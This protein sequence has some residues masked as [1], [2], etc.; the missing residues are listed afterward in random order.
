MPDPS[1]DRTP[2]GGMPSG[3]ANHYTTA[4]SFMIEDYVLGLFRSLSFSRANES[5]TGYTFISCEWYFTCPD[6]GNR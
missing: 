6:L 1:G 5:M 4:L 2:T 3:R